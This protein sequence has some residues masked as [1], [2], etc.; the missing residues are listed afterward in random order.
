MNEPCSHQSSHWY[1]CVCVCV[2]VVQAAPPAML[3]E[4][5]V[6]TT[7]WWPPSS[8]SWPA[9]RNMEA[10][11]PP[12]GTGECMFSFPSELITANTLSAQSGRSLTPENCC[13]G[14]QKRGEI[15][16]ELFWRPASP[17]I[18][19]R[20]QNNSKLLYCFKRA[21]TILISCIFSCDK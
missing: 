10:R 9:R 5:P 4:P 11:N 15:V 21:G 12:T 2:C 6:S 20:V 19:W 16:S 14:E 7:L 13:F 8:P 1:L 17:E 3:W 18:S